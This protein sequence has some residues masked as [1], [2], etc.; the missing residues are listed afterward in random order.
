MGESEPQDSLHPSHVTRPSDASSYDEICVNC[1][2]TD[3]VGSWGKL[4]QP[5]PS[6]PKDHSVARLIGAATYFM[7]SL[8]IEND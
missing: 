6:E 7:D 2:R 3:S 8:E 4:M 5:C 1:G